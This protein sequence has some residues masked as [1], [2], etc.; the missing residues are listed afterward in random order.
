MSKYVD[1]ATKVIQYCKNQEMDKLKAILAEAE[2]YFL[3]TKEY[4]KLFRIYS[5]I[6]AQMASIGNLDMLVEY[7]IRFTVLY[8]DLNVAVGRGNYLSTQGYLDMILC[9]YEG[10]LEKAKLAYEEA[11]KSNNPIAKGAEISNMA[12][13]YLKLDDYD[14]ALKKVD[15]A[16]VLV[17]AHKMEDWYFRISLYFTLAECLIMKKDYER[18]IRVLDE[19][20]QTKEYES[21]IIERMEYDHIMG[22][23]FYHIE[24]Y[25]QSLAYYRRSI[26]IAEQKNVFFELQKMYNGIAKVLF[27]LEYIEESDIYKEK[28]DEITRE[29]IERA[30]NSIVQKA[31]MSIEFDRK[32]KA[33]NRKQNSVGI[34]VHLNTNKYDELTEVLTKKYLF[35]KLNESFSEDATKAL[36]KLLIIE[37]CNIEEIVEN[38]SPIYGDKF[39]Y[40]VS[41]I[42]KGNV[43]DHIIGRIDTNRF[44]V[45]YSLIDKEELDDQVKWLLENLR[46]SQITIKDQQYSIKFNHEIIDL[47]KLRKDNKLPKLDMYTIIKS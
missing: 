19:I 13:V 17:K 46:G 29:T 8:E 20:T 26:L 4:D 7:L 27:K 24:D 45:V 14:M 44:L 33:A 2:E 37:L 31:Q 22:L 15:E 41:K 32:I 21:S 16:E 25:E 11:C 30:N 23:Y 1:Y 40:E 36:P 28:A 34:G 3:L 6:P 10:A 38:S 42:L 43:D 5:E 35:D 47:E 12:M 39:I 18:A 9:D